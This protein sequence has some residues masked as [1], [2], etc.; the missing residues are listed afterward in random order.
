M[1]GFTVYKHLKTGRRIYIQLALHETLRTQ[2]GSKQIE[3]IVLVCL[4][5]SYISSRISNH[6]FVPTSVEVE[7]DLRL[8]K[9][10]GSKLVSL[11]VD[12]IALEGS[13]HRNGRTH[14]ILSN[15]FLSL[16]SQSRKEQQTRQNCDFLHYCKI[17][18]FQNHSINFREGREPPLLSVLWTPDAQNGYTAHADRCC[19][20]DWSGANHTSNLP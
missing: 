4:C 6:T 9:I 13:A 17:K 3:Q 20:R 10:A 11:E 18:S 14:I 1:L 2:I 5:H 8:Q 7:T 16:G 15:S 12:T 19:R